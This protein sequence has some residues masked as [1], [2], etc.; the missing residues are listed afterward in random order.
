M[1]MSPSHLGS[2]DP[3]CDHSVSPFGT[4]PLCPSRPTGSHLGY[5]WGDFETEE[6][7]VEDE[8]YEYIRQDMEKDREDAPGS[9]S[10]LTPT[11]SGSEWWNHHEPEVSNSRGSQGSDPFQDPAIKSVEDRLSCLEEIVDEILGSIQREIAQMREQINERMAQIEQSPDFASEG[12]QEYPDEIDKAFDA[13]LYDATPLES[14]PSKSI[15]DRYIEDWHNGG[16]I[17]VENISNQAGV[18]DVQDVFHAC[19]EITYIEL[20]GPNALGPHV[21]TRHA[22][23]HF[24]QPTQATKA[25]HYYHGFV[26]RDKTLMVF[27]LGTSHV[28]GE[29]GIPYAGT[30]LEILNFNGGQNFHGGQTFTGGQKAAEEPTTSSLKPK[31]TI[32]KDVSSWRPM[33][34]PKAAPLESKLT[35][36]TFVP[37]ND[38]TAET[39]APAS[40]IQLLDPNTTTNKR[41]RHQPKPKLTINTSV[42]RADL[43]TEKSC[44]A[45]EPIVRPLSPVKVDTQSSGTH[46]FYGESDLVQFKFASLVESPGDASDDEMVVFQG[47]RNKVLRP[48]LATKIVKPDATEALRALTKVNGKQ[49]SH[50]KKNNVFSSWKPWTIVRKAVCFW[51]WGR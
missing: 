22:F 44:P 39:K 16:L 17:L 46:L 43:P 25:R 28:R 50:A 23:V 7:L 51:K 5:N 36:N 29:P 14:L 38:D 37:T 12:V 10:D 20:H 21:A 4:C 49:V 41:A 47:P 26:F 48:C 8:L 13:D 40:E 6:D 30:A 45:P 9:P 3:H 11:T 27:L 33:V 2:W 15:A 35:I 19:G 42:T 34:T 32:K 1:H 18:R 24:A 31:L